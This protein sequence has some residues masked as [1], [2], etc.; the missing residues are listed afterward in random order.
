MGLNEGSAVGKN[1]GLTV[2]CSV[3][4]LVGRK[5]GCSD[6]LDEEAFTDDQLIPAM[7]MHS[8]K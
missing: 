2:G 5:V 4:I 3:G 7:N 8:E 1:V 6:G